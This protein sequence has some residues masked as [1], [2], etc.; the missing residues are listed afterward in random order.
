MVFSVSAV[1]PKT[2]AAFRWASS[3]ASAKAEPSAGRYQLGHQFAGISYRLWRGN[4]SRASLAATCPDPD[5]SIDSP[6]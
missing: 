3:R 5:S 6:A 1:K 2:P 4:L